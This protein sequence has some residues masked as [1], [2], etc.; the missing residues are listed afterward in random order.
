[1]IT[2][3]NATKSSF[4]LSGNTPVAS[5]VVLNTER[6]EKVQLFFISYRI[7]VHLVGDSSL[8]PQPGGST[9]FHFRLSKKTTTLKVFRY[10]ES[11]AVPTQRI[12]FLLCLTS[13]LL[14]YFPSNGIPPL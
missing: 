3:I 8:G 7:K 4:I 10:L 6:T 12:R 2:T 13:W 11:L 1:M 14:I 5:S 9:F